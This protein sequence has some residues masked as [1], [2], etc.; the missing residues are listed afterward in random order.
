MAGVRARK[1]KEII[2]D[3]REPLGLLVEYSQRFPVFLGRTRLPRKSDLR[4][5]AQNRNRGP[6]FVRRIGHEALLAFE[7]LTEPVQ[8]AVERPGQVPQ[9]V[10]VILHRQPLVQ[11]GGADAPG[12]AAHGHDGGEALPREK[13]TARAGE[14]ESDGDDPCKRRGDLFKHF[15]LRM[16]RLQDH[17]RAGLSARRKVPRECPVAG[18]VAPDLAKKAFG[19][20]RSAEK[21]LK[22]AR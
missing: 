3:V 8:Q 13:V 22:R 4:F 6:Q 18:L 5:A 19:A 7:R 9:F 1:R 2:H 21:S 20:R 16:K 17:Q 12:L 15:L 14:Q 11:I 10:P